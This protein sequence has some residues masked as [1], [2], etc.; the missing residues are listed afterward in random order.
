MKRQAVLPKF[1][2]ILEQMGENIKLARKRRKLTAV[3]VAERAGIARSTL[4]LIEK[5]DSSVAMGAYFNVLRVLGLQDDFLKLAADDVF[6]RKLQ[7]LD[8]L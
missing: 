6:G 2:A 1:Q 7:D 3:Q 8:L 5:G 4:Y